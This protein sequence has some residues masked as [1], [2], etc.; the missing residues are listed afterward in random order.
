MN[1]NKQEGV[2][3]YA[4]GSGR[5]DIQFSLEEYYGGLNCGE[6]F[7]IYINRQW[8]PVRIEYCH[9]DQDWYLVGVS[10]DIGLQGLKVRV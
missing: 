2:L 10:R 3:V 5:Y 7:D 4:F 9:K 6:C 1:S 8:K